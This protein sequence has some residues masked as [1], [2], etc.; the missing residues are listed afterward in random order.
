MSETQTIYHCNLVDELPK[1][2][3]EQDIINGL[4]SGYNLCCVMWYTSYWQV[5]VND[6]YS[7]D[8][9]AYIPETDEHIPF[10]INPFYGNRYDHIL[11]PSCIADNLGV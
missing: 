11:C 6:Q 3:M 2:T 10:T 1:L 8:R 7:N 4:S 5:L 9:E